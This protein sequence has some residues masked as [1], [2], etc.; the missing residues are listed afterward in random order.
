MI[1]MVTAE[2][3]AVREY[4][5]RHVQKCVKCSKMSVGDEILKIFWRGDTA[6]SLYSTP[7][8][9]GH[10]FPNSPSR[11]L[12]RLVPHSKILATPLTLLSAKYLIKTDEENNVG[13]DCLMRYTSSFHGTSLNFQWL[14]LAGQFQLHDVWCQDTRLRLYALSCRSAVALYVSAPSA[15][16]LPAR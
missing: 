13:W 7:I 15:S 1:L 4:R 9:R 3:V 5:F 8:G 2:A 14:I 6:L 16:F 12:R 10:S 11:R